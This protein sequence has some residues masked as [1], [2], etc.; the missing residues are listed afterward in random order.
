MIV[1][2]MTSFIYLLLRE[3]IPTGKGEEISLANLKNCKYMLAQPILSVQDL[4][5]HWLGLVS[6]VRFIGVLSSAIPHAG[7]Y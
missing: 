5:V 4:Q 6:G 2:I 3:G 7:F 1:F